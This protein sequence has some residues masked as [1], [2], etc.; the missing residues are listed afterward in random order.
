MFSHSDDNQRKS[1]DNRV[2]TIIVH[3]QLIVSVIKQQR[4][5]ESSDEP[6][7]LLNYTLSEAFA[8]VYTNL[9]GLLRNSSGRL[10]DHFVL[11]L[12]FPLGQWA[13]PSLDSLRLNAASE[14]S[15]KDV[16]KKDVF[17]KHPINIVV[18]DRELTEYLKVLLNPSSQV[19]FDA[20]QE[21]LTLA[22]SS[23]DADG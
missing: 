16:D 2:E 3:L 1:F 9:R 14:S 4:E 17:D 5:S 10:L 15:K 8:T 18:D 19:V 21:D 7:V 22:V 13:Q 12:I 23:G 6:S 20:F 11:F